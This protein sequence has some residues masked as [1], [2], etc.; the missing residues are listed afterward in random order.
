MNSCAF[1]RGL[2]SLFGGAKDVA[3][4]VVG[5]V[6]V[7]D[8]PLGLRALAGTWRAQ[9]YEVEFRHGE[10]RQSI[11]VWSRSGS[12]FRFPLWEHPGFAG[13]VVPREGSLDRLPCVHSRVPLALA[14]S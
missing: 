3:G 1:L 13:R 7:L 9:E 4:G 8:E 14:V 12:G 10:A 2:V 6:E 5:Q 11:A